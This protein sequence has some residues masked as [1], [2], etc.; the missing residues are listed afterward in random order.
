[1]RPAVL[2]FLLILPWAAH[3]QG[4]TCDPQGNVAIFSNY[5][6]GA[7]TISVDQ[8]I[9]DLKIGV[10]SY[11]FSR[12]TLTG[13][14]ASNVTA[15]WYAG[16]DA[17]NDHCSLGGT[18]LST[19][20]TGAPPGTDSIIL[21]PPATYANANGWPSIICNHSCDVST[22]QGGCNTADQIAHWFLTQW[23]GTLL[24]HFTQY[25]CWGN[26]YSI[27]AGGNCC[28][29]P[30][31]TGIQEHAS[32]EAV[33]ELSLVGD[34]LE[35]HGA[36]PVEILDPLGRIIHRDRDPDA[37]ARSFDLAGAPSGT[38]LVRSLATRAARRFAIAR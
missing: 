2:P 26:G 38:Y 5:D 6:G 10:V 15:L 3:A 31:A 24:F 17:G 23:N 12:I 36:G 19:T 8:N 34:L 28:E 27:S 25:G 35:V 21:Y 29:N 7:L 33:L 1:M 9:P 13:A 30:L 14:Y 22:D 37:I 16:F 4:M 20:I 32:G 18:T 11:E